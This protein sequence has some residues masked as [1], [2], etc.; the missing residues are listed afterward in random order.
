MNILVHTTFRDLRDFLPVQEGDERPNENP[1]APVHP[2][3]QHR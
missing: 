2:S 3:H 1:G